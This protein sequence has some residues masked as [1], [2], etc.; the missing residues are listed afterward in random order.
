MNILE[1]QNKLKKIV[2]KAE[3]KSFIYDLLLAYGLPKASITRLKK[4]AYDLSKRDDRVSWKKKVLFQHESTLAE[5]SF[6]FSIGSKTEES[7]KKGLQTFSVSQM[8]NFMWRACK[9]AVTYQRRS[10]ISTRQAT[11]LIAGNISRAIDQ[12]IA[13]DWQVKPYNRKYNEPQSALS[14][15]LFNHLLLTDDGSFNRTIRELI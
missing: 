3:H 13:N 4:G 15:V 8:Y 9:D 11:N 7:L 6:N 14:Q 5:Y 10:N 12:A 1:T 2:K